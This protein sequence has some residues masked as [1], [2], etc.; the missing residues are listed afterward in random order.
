[1]SR[2]LPDARPDFH[3]EK[4]VAEPPNGFYIL[5]NLF[6]YHAACYMTHAPIE[7]GHLRDR[8]G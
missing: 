6:K 8:Q 7:C 4:G 2:A 5:A 3:P 1:M